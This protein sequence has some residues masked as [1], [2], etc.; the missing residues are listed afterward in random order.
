MSTKDVCIGCDQRSDR[1]VPAEIRFGPGYNPPTFCQLGYKQN[2]KTELAVYH[3]L[4][5]GG[6]V[7]RRIQQSA[8]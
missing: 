5:A 7:C 8:E 3:A 2:P 4:R 1:D 6:E